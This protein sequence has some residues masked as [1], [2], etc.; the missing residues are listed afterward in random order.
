MSASRFLAENDAYRL[1]EDLGTKPRVYYIPGHGE[2]VGR[3][4]F[5]PT[6]SR[7][8]GPGWNGPRGP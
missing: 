6:G 4:V 5:T 1:K 2:A 3:D 8:N 7:P